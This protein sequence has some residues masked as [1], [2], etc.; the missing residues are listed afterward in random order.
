[1]NKAR[2][3]FL[4]V[5][6]ALLFT[7]LNLSSSAAQLWLEKMDLRAMSSGYGRSR[8]GLSVEGNP[9]KMAGKTYARGVGTHA[10]SQMVIQLDGKAEKFQATVGLDHETCPG[11]SA[12][13]TLVG[14]NKTLWDSGTLF[15]GTTRNINV[16]LL[17]IKK[18]V[19]LVND[20]G[21]GKDCDHADWANARFIFK[22]KAP[23]IMQETTQRW[24]L[25][26]TGG[27]TWDAG[28]DTHLPHEDHIEMSGRK[29]SMI[30]RYGADAS[31]RLTLGR[32]IV[33]PMLRTVPNN[34]HASLAHDFGM[35]SSPLETCV[36]VNNAP[37]GKIKLLKVE[38]RG[39]IS[40]YGKTSSGI[41]VLWKIF[42][43]PQK[44]A[45]IENIT[46]T[47]ASPDSQALEI[48]PFHQSFATDSA[49][50]VDGVYLLDS[51]LAGSGIKKLL[52]GESIQCSFVFTGRKAS[53][54][55]IALNPLE[56]ETSRNN[57]IDRLLNN[58]QFECP[59]PEL[60]T[61]FAF[62]KIRA[63]ESIFATKGGLLH[64]PGGGAYYAAIWA[65]DQAEYANP[66]FPYLG[67][68]GG[69][70]SALNA[71]RHF[72][73]FMTP[74]YKPVPSS[75]IA[76]GLDIWNGA[77]D[78]GDAA[79]IAYGASR[80]AL[81]SGDKNIAEELWPSIQWCLEYCRRK[82]NEEG[83]ITSDCDELEGRF[84]A[85][86]ANLCTSALNYDALISAAYLGESLGK[87]PEIIKEYL[88]R[89][90]GLK[91]AIE[92][93]FG[94]TV[95][96]YSTYRYYDGNTTLRAWIC[97]PLTMGIMDRSEG[98]LQALFSPDLWTADGLATEAGK[99]TFWDRSTLYGFRGAFAAGAT[100]KA[101]SYFRAYSRRRLLGNHVPYPVEAWPEG[102]QRH[103]SA[104]SA[105]YCRV[106]TEGIFGI[107]PIGLHSF[108]C[109]PRLPEK[110]NQM[111]L[112]NVHGY[113]SLFDIEVA[114]ENH[115]LILRVKT[116]GK[117]VYQ[118]NFKDG[119]I[120]SISMP[121]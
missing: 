28:S 83:V 56:E 70:E 98:T 59:E 29:I 86:N 72:A 77:G 82:T 58:L 35:E 36:L 87:S 34:T 102:N 17:G 3:F 11:G 31:G 81:T 80:Y 110:W 38:H 95:A 105:L 90:A 53:E 103:L 88:E 12:G 15:P 45:I 57:Y 62:A 55:E 104:E 75:I 64:G 49:K 91:T 44:P 18:L 32:H 114:R 111:A 2:K 40:L 26:S 93:Y 37:L 116:Q 48:K 23:Q 97:I 41:N 115:Q 85:G 42:P 20:G 79:M 25:N 106:V 21:N 84:P 117:T 100:E 96:G 60:S 89:A 69:N 109:Q 94:A 113:G 19:L 67:D 121:E 112:R 66:F 5:L 76:E 9:L 16:N 6:V 118:A 46:L 13:F 27:I 24:S 61:L 7:L 65:N 78:R 10:P 120:L 92:K 39:M 33:W 50:G 22:G 8:A 73:R 63:A 107:R 4:I 108:Q 47:N 1:M 71:Y 101:L 14:D 99:E 74:E 119:D 52:P 30:I 43:S 68:E 54:P 51:D